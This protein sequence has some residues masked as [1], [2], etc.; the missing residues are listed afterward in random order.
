[1]GDE[2][3]A[4]AVVSASLP[5]SP[6]IAGMALEAAQALREA[7]PH[8]AAQEALALWWDSGLRE[9]V[10]VAC[11]TQARAQTRPAFGASTPFRDALRRL[12]VTSD[13]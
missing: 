5:Y 6:L 9:G 12:T 10:F 4:P 2:S 11:M 13:Q 8:L 3:H 1:V 7:R